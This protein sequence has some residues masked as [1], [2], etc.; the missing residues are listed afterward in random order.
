MKGVI[1]PFFRRRR[2]NPDPP[3]IGLADRSRADNA[4]AARHMSDA[5]ERAIEQRQ[6]LQADFLAERAAH[7]A[8]C[9]PRL[10]ECLARLRLAQGQ[11]QTALGIIEGRRKRS[12]SLRLL[13]AVCLLQLGRT[14]EAHVDLH[15]WSRNSS[16]PL[17]ARL[18]LGLLEW[19][20][21]DTEAAMTALRRNLKHLDDPRT[22]EALLLVSLQRD[23]ADQA[24]VWADRL[25]SYATTAD[26]A[27]ELNLLLRS[28][29]MAEAAV[30]GDPSPAQVHTLAMELIAQDG[31]IP[32]LV[33]ASRLRPQPA[34]A[35]LLGLAI[36]YALDDLRHPQA[37]MEALARLSSLQGDFGTAL[38]WAKRGLARNPM[39]ASLAL[40]HRELTRRADP[41]RHGHPMAAVGAATAAADRE[42]AA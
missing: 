10:A 24:R 2:R 15:R 13:R 38:G 30:A 14:S 25:R 35:R 21:G 26:T 27:P 16:A 11:P 36:E 32:A 22:L 29:G 34:V 40:L 7:L 12:S 33:E 39:S 8:A 9:H 6:W 31:V 17:E 28:L 20:A 3:A 1:A 23:R 41:Q 5:I 42:K 18:L 37:A 4:P 19:A